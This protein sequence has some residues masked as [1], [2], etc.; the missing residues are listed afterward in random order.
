M[1]Y[2]SGDEEQE[3]LKYVTEAVEVAQNATCERSKC[4]SVIVHLG[5]IIG[6]GFNSPPQDIEE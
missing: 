6:S 2:L 1:K 3:A 5:E 4:G